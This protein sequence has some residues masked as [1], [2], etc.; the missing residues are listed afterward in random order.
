MFPANGFL[1]NKELEWLCSKTVLI[2]RCRL[3][4][5]EIFCLQQCLIHARR[6]NNDE[7]DNQLSNK[8]YEKQNG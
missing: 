4:Q 1:K 5:V 3:L 6:P 8:Q 2:R 7:T